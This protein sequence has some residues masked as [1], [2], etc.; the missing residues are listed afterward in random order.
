AAVMTLSQRSAW[1]PSA[2]Q[3]S[4]APARPVATQWA[5]DDSRQGSAAHVSWPSAHEQRTRAPES[6]P[7][8]ISLQTGVAMSSGDKPRRGSAGGADKFNSK[9]VRP[10]GLESTAASNSLSGIQVAGSPSGRACAGNKYTLSAR[11]VASDRK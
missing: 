4:A 2:A 5:N 6:P 11:D 7:A 1:R 9:S 3:P 8:S 10:R